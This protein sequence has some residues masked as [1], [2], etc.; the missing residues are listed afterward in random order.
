MGNELHNVG[1]C[2]KT[3]IGHFLDADVCNYLVNM[4]IFKFY[5]QIFKLSKARENIKS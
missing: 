4:F 3:Y 1:K 2:G 5:T